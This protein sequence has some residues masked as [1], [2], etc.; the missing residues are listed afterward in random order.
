MET[1]PRFTSL[2]VSTRRPGA[3]RCPR[4]AAWEARLIVDGAST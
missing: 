4:A 2:V 1:A 3:A